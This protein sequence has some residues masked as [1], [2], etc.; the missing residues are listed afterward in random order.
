MRFDP[1][2]LRRGAVDVVDHRIGWVS[3]M[4]AID[5]P[6]RVVILQSAGRSAPD[7][8]CGTQAEQSRDRDVLAGFFPDFAVHRL[9]GALP[10]VDPAPREAPR[11]SRI[12]PIAVC[13]EQHSS[14]ARHERVARHALGHVRVLV[15]FNDEVW[16]L[17]DDDAAGVG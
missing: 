10:R 7:P 9:L 11:P 5:D 6:H 3:A 4:G 17:D 1:T 8:A 14:G 16:V 12:R 13:R 2:G 15:W